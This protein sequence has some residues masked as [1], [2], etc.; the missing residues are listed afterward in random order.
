MDANKKRITKYDR[1]MSRLY[2]RSRST[3]DSSSNVTRHR[4][5]PSARGGGK[6][7]SSNLSSGVFNELPVVLDDYVPEKPVQKTFVVKPRKTVK[8]LDPSKMPQQT[9]LKPTASQKTIVNS[10]YVRG[11]GSTPSVIYRSANKWP[12]EHY[13]ECMSSRSHTRLKELKVSIIQEVGL[14]S[15]FLTFK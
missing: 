1:V 5:S 13:R 10:P 14:I 2:N 11:R 8:S 6:A 3:V 15:F 9:A 12:D 4:V 7:S